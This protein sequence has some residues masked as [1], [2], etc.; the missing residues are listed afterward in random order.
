M[1]NGNRS[2]LVWVHLIEDQS[3]IGLAVPYLYLTLDLPKKTLM[4]IRDAMSRT[5]LVAQ[6][7]LRCS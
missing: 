5:Q 3:V 1:Q 2:V 4:E 7:Q 6:L